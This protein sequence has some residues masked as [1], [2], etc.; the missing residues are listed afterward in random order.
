MG[1]ILIDGAVAVI[2]SG[3]EVAQLAADAD[4]RA[5]EVLGES[6][7][8][9]HGQRKATVRVSSWKAAVLV[10]TIKHVEEVFG[11]VGALLEEQSLSVEEAIESMHHSCESTRKN[12]KSKGKRRKHKKH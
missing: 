8:L 11:S 7:L 5:A 12:E 2:Q 1:F 10:I 9:G 3:T 6:A 4:Y